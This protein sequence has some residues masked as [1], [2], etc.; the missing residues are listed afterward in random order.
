LKQ[1]REKKAEDAII[2]EES[3]N[4]SISEIAVFDPKSEEASVQVSTPFVS[5]N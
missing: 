5:S 1:F 2:Q 4:P 3:S